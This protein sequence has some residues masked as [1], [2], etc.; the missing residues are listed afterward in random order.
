MQ[1]R[2]PLYMWFAAN[3]ISDFG[4]RLTNLAIPWFVL[5][6]TGSLSK[7]GVTGFFSVLP[8]VLATFFGGPLIE[9][10]GYKRVSVLADI[11]S[12]IT[13][14]LVPLLHA[15]VGLSFWQ[16]QV[17]VFLG[18]FLDAPGSTARDA[19]VPELGSAA[20]VPLERVNAISQVAYRLTVLG[21]PLVGGL[22]IGAIGASNVLWVD[23]VTFAISAVLIGA[24][25]PAGLVQ[26]PQPQ[27]GGLAGYVRDLTEGLRFV[28]AD[29]LVFT[30]LA[31]ITVAN[32]LDSPSSSVL[33]PGYA[34]Q[35]I[36]SPTALGG[37]LSAMGLGSVL[38]A[39]VFAAVGPRLPRRIVYLVA[40]VVVALPI[41]GMAQLPGLPLMIAL[42]FLYG[43]GAG[44]LNPIIGTVLQERVPLEMRGRVFG[45]VKALAWMAMPVGPVLG[46]FAAEAW[47]LRP[48]YTA[49]AVVYLLLVL[50]QF[51]NPAIAEMDLTAAGSQQKTRG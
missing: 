13:V 50:A 38:S 3:I 21:G 49:I 25:I 14:A 7:A 47:G 16:L 23:A 44:P 51:F 48:T 12:G 43:V 27:G 10:L 11:L 33:L 9:R 15:T 40:W 19:M 26:Q 41:L 4:N 31:V 46:G 45:L 5:E 18:A 22:L 2:T 1:Q 30:M 34:E 29:R 35:V 20:G 37:V 42:A 39:L 17:L 24:G 8:I 32:F 36:G 6:T 28:R